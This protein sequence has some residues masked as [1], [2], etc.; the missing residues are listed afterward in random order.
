MKKI[1]AALVILLGISF[2]PT[3]SFQFS[4]HAGRTNMGDALSPEC[5]CGVPGPP[6]YDENTWQLCNDPHGIVLDASRVAGRAKPA[7]PYST[8]DSSS[9]D[10]SVVAFGAVTLMF[11]L[12]RL[13]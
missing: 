7:R 2:L 10:Y 3:L 4:A 9:P 13:F 11:W 12:K 5:S 6:C 8:G 1:F